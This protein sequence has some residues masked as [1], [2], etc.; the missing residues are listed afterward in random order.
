MVEEPEN[1]SQLSLEEA[2]KIDKN[3]LLEGIVEQEFEATSFGRVA[4]QTA[5]QVLLQKLREAEREVV[6]KDFD[7]KVGQV[8][9]GTVAR[10]EPRIVRIE[11]GHGSGI[12]PASEQVPGERLNTG[13]RIKVLLKEIERDQRGPQ[14]ILSRADADFVKV[15]FQQ[16]VPEIETGAVEI[17][18]IAREAGR[19]TK[20]A[21]A[22]S[23][24]VSTQSV[25]LSAAR[26]F[27]SRT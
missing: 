20:I 27:A 21:V 8:I 19:R 26:V 25:L 15:L 14:I 22:S 6:A 4:A 24:Q 11:I 9:T 12:M 13:S 23:V 16:E 2:K 1:A 7:D 18:A 17:K 3:A 5:K 10:V